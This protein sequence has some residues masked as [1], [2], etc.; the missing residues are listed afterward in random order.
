MADKIPENLLTGYWTGSSTQWIGV[1]S[2]R[3][4][5]RA[6]GTVCA[7]LQQRRLRTSV[8][9]LFCPLLLARLQA[10]A[11]IPCTDQFKTLPHQGFL[12]FRSLPIWG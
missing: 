12:S 4:A 6:A 3:A 10:T 7:K 5:G 8:S 2:G 9:P 1:T 11:T